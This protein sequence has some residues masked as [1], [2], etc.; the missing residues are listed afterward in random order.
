M[1]DVPASPTKNC[2][3]CD[4]EIRANAIKCKHC[5]SLLENIDNQPSVVLTT[6]SLVGHQI[7]QYRLT[8]LLGDGGMGTVYLAEHIALKQEVAIK[9]MD[10]QLASNE[11]LRKHFIQE[12]E[13][14]MGL[15]HPSI[16]RVL[17]ACTDEP[18]L[19]LV[20]EYI[21]GL[22][23][24]QVLDRRGV[25]PLDEA[26]KLFKQV[27]SGVGYANE[28]GIVHRDIKPANIMV[29]A[30][31]TAKV[32]DFGI[33]KVL[34][35]TR[36]TLTGTQM[37]SVH[38]MSPEQVLGRKNINHSTDIYSLGATLY[39]VLTGRTPFESDEEDSSN[40]D[41][42]I[43]DA[44]VRVRPPAPREIKAAIPEAVS[45]AIL[46]ALEKEPGKRFQSCD[47][48]ACCLLSCTKTAADE[49]YDVS[50][51]LRY[52]YPNSPKEI[53]TQPAGEKSNSS[54][55]SVN[56]EPP[57][58]KSKPVSG[59]A[60]PQ[61]LKNVIPQRKSP[62]KSEHKSKSEMHTSRTK[63]KAH[64]K[65]VPTKGSVD[66]KTNIKR[67]AITTNLNTTVNETDNIRKVF[68]KL[69]DD[70]NDVMNRI[71]RRNRI[72][73][74]MIF[75]VIAVTI[76]IIVAAL[77]L[78]N[79]SYHSYQTRNSKHPV[80]L[81]TE[82]ADSYKNNRT[83]RVI[84]F[85]TILFKSSKSSK[86]KKVSTRRKRVKKK[87]RRRRKRRKR[88]ARKRTKSSRKTASVQKDISSLIRAYY[89]GLDK[90]KVKYLYSLMTKRCIIREKIFRKSFTNAVKKYNL[91][92][93]KYR[94]NYIRKD[95]NSAKVTAIATF[96]RP[97]G[98][99]AREGM[100]FMLVKTN[101]RWWINGVY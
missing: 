83:R 91:H 24:A 78:K 54:N 70:T 101:D 90:H 60:E 71:K 23:L 49:R 80:K 6:D 41:Y 48:F 96:I 88:R 40:S 62:Q 84:R 1:S 52:G 47:E 50:E 32:T 46:K 81:T 12:A 9:V 34:G 8:R 57:I 66:K 17:T 63:S 25:L 36:I 39:E 11:K 87:S 53:S 16:V 59:I 73:Y 85:N 31:G 19:A 68:D 51:T 2:P 26:L 89:R 100:R 99:P 45:D 61:P 43:K 82:H 20:M 77:K 55:V 86:A 35:G 67:N 79:S 10:P 7:L 5:K 33:A 69:R 27:L 76:I 65:S 93:S 38:Y 97:N 94:V 29:Q 30:D 56:K 21:E 22:S 13:I 15:V 37:G 28:H 42:V 44:H 75:T 64:Q 14:Q 98:R 72:R 58:I 92:L 4:E 3:F 95:G 18:F 74:S